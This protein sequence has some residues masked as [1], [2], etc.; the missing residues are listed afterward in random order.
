MMNFQD[1]KSDLVGMA[2]DARGQVGDTI[3]HGREAMEHG[4]EAIADSAEAIPSKLEGMIDGGSRR[5]RMLAS[6]VG[7]YA[8]IK[9]LASA[10]DAMPSS[11]RI[12]RAFGMQRRP[13]GLAQ[14][15]TGVGIFAA[16]AAVGAGVALLVAPREGKQTRAMINS[17]LRSL[18]SDAT[19]MAHDVETA[20]RD[21]VHSAEDGAA[22]AVH[23]V[24]NAVRG[25][26]TP[27]EEGGRGRARNPGVSHRTPR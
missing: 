25:T 24:T 15:F 11:K 9:T 1:L 22:D 13:S 20:A 6:V 5:I 10:L 27:N 18:R 26:S 19:H 8:S 3:E 23:D 16:G 2:R 17:R 14:A 4:R 21:A 7:A 12:L